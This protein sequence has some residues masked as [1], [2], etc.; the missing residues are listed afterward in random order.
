MTRDQILMSDRKLIEAAVQA[1]ANAYVPYSRF[2]VGAAPL[3]TSGKV[4]LGCNV[5]NVSLGLTLCAER[6]AV[7]A[8][9]AGGENDSMRIMTSTISSATQEFSLTDLLLRYRDDRYV[10]PAHRKTWEI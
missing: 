8:A 10:V 9:I 5:E 4:F 7:A 6:S 2:P 3:T 1:R